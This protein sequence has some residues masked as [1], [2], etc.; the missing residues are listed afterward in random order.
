MKTHKPEIYRN[1]RSLETT[2]YHEAGHAI[3]RRLTSIKF[4]A[5]VAR[6]DAKG[7]I[8]GYVGGDGDPH[9]ML[10]S[11]IRDHKKAFTPFELP[12]KGTSIHKALAFRHCCSCLAGMQSELILKSVATDPPLMR[13]DSDHSQ[14]AALFSEAFGTT[15]LQYP[16]AV[17][18][19]YLARCW[20]EVRRCAE[21]LLRRHE[22]DG[23]GAIKRD[24]P[25]DAGF[26]SRDVDGAVWIDN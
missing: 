25:R 4:N 17:A 2:A 5:I 23:I 16:Q 10:D 14:A 20:G 9:T 12:T 19:S 1:E 18:R 7:V 8:A 11:M 13:A 6:R 3:L 26:F 21:E 22:R 15:D 24:D